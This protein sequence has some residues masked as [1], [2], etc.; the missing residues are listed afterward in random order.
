MGKPRDKHVKQKRDVNKGVNSAKS[1]RSRKTE[2]SE[3]SESDGAV[4]ADLEQLRIS[5]SG[6]GIQM[7]PSSEKC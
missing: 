2:W 6:S 7:F 5:E 3:H 4:A 1:I